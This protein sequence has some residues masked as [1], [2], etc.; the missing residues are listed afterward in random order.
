MRGKKKEEEVFTARVVIQGVDTQMPVEVMNPLDENVVL[1]KHIQV[2]IISRLPDLGMICSLEEKGSPGQTNEASSELPQELESLL[3]K[4]EVEVDL[5]QRNQIRQLIK[6]HQDVFSLPGQPLGQTELVKHDIVTQ[7]Q[8]PIKKA[9]RRPPFHLK[10]TA[11]REVQR[12]LQD[13]IIEPS[14]SPWASPVVLVW[15]KGWV[16]PVLY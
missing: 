7:S 11:E 12:M 13:D 10:T 4:V 16:Y 9:V 1:F 14:N 8:T 15:K 6:E 2:E 3:N 5:E